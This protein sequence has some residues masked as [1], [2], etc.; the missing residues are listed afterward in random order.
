M[1]E[2]LMKETKIEN[3]VTL[4]KAPD[5]NWH[6]V[7]NEHLTKKIEELDAGAHE[8]LKALIEV[9][10]EWSHA[11][12]HV[13]IYVTDAIARARDLFAVCLEKGVV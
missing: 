12:L 4:F 11:G 7:S 9:A 5:G 13:P 6:P 2:T 8:L 3:G 1:D 10:D